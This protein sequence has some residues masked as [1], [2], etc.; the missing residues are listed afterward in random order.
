MNR[1][2]E[3]LD[4]AIVGRHFPNFGLYVKRLVG[5]YSISSHAIPV[6]ILAI[7]GAPTKF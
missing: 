6:M 3:M 5:K 1:I 2:S 4:L 7:G